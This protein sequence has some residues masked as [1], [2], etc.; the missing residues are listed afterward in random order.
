[1]IRITVTDQLVVGLTSSST[2]V[3]AV[4]IVIID[5]LLV[6][7]LTSSSTVVGVVVIVIIDDLLVVGLTSSSTVV[8]VVVIVIVCY[9]D[10]D[11]CNQCLS[12]LKLWI[13][14]PLR[15]CVLDTTFI[16][17]YSLS[18]TCGR[19]VVLSGYSRFLPTNKTGCH[20]II[21]EILLKVV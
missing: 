3:G 19:S 11:M 15:R 7:G 4:V 10:I 6:V 1:M 14:T 21:A 2:V 5:D 16:M 13:C 17:W 9:W 12:P 18:V 8:G 20:Y